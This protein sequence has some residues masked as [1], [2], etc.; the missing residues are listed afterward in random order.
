M[1]TPRWTQADTDRLTDLHSQGLSLGKI[2]EQMGRGKATISTRA[3]AAGLT[4]DRDQVAAATQA[5]T[6]DAKARRA[7]IK[8]RLLTRVEANL[9]RLD[10][11]TFHTLVPSGPGIHD[12]RQLSFV[13]PDDEKHLATSITSYLGA[14]DR[15]EKLDGDGG[16]ADAVGMLDKIADAIKGAAQALDA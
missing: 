10:A 6:R 11:D 14:Y 16:V 12:P 13:P 15:L 8:L 1:A 4:W 3:K 9:D 5:K 7:D 2:A